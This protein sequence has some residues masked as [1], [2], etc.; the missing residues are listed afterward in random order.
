M[1]DVW[2]VLVVLAFFGLCVALVWRCD[3]IIGP[4]E[5]EDASESVSEPVVA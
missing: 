3:H 2:V 1:A 4:D 5:L